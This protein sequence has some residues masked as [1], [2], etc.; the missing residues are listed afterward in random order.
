MKRTLLVAVSIM[1][2]LFAFTACTND[3]GS[4]SVDEDTAQNIANEMDLNALVNNVFSEGEG[5]GVSI[6]YMLESDA[7]VQSA[8]VPRSAG[9]TLTATVT[10]DGYKY[11]T[12]TIESGVLRYVFTGS[13][14]GMRF[15]ASSYK[16][17][18][19]RALV[20]QSSKASE[21][22]DVAI[23][24]K[25]AAGAAFSA[26]LTSIES[27]ET[28]IAANTQSVSVT[29]PA[30]DSVTIDNQPVTVPEEETPTPDPEPS[31]PYGF[32]GGNGTESN[33]Y[34]IANASQFLRIGS[35]EFQARLLEGDNDDLYFRLTGD[36]DLSNQKGYA[37]RV[38]SGTLDGDNH[39][40]ICSN[41]MPFL[42]EYSFENMTFKDV[43]I[44]FG[45]S[46]VTR[47]FT[48]PAV[49][50]L[51]EDNYKVNGDIYTYYY[52]YDKDSIDLVF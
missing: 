18:T 40:I 31:N 16:I 28:F 13:L 47:L 1:L 35:D 20:V 7:A 25:E 10:F 30:D 42:F 19:E 22:V 5:K 39:K 52:R 21:S 32:A 9:Y 3:N 12:I 48:Y 17:E 45:D 6:T 34:L 38:I 8:A 49:R 15:S 11:S 46:S 43:M 44:E 14:N 23:N 41:D 2:L 26:T 24:V 51:Y 36:I 27:G 50:A 29:I 4:T 33:P 37:A